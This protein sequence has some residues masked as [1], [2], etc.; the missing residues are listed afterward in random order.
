MRPLPR[1][2]DERLLRRGISLRYLFGI[3]VAKLLH[4]KAN[5]IEEAQ[6]LRYSFRRILENARDLFD[7]LELALRV[8]S[9]QRARLA[10][11]LLFT[12]AGHDIKQRPAIAVVHERFCR[13][14]QARAR[15]RSELLQPPDAP[16]VFAIELE[17]RG[18]PSFTR[19]LLDLLQIITQ[20]KRFIAE[21]E[22]WNKDRLQ[23]LRVRKIIGKIQPALAL[24][25]APVSNGQQPREVRIA[26]AILRIDNE[27]GRSVAKHEPRADD[28]MK[29]ALAFLTHRL[30]FD[31]GAHDASQRVAVSDAQSCQTKRDRLLDHL[32]RMRS[33]TQEREVGRYAK[34]SKAAHAKSP[35]TYQRGCVSVSP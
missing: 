32:F 16:A 4:G 22:R 12:N 2:R 31:I 23:P 35:W 3:F 10:Q 29:I 24:R 33:R 9:K 21:F 25:R 7:R 6:A 17:G 19:A 18:K 1:Q 11:F 13:R 30:G 14:Q 15:L 34:F 27:I 5:A 26:C 8:L 20:R 28:H